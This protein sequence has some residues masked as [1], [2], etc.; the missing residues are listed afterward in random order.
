MKAKDL[1]TCIA[2]GKIK[3]PIHVLHD[4]HPRIWCVTIFVPMVVIT[5]VGVPMTFLY[6]FFVDIPRIWSNFWSDIRGFWYRN[7]RYCKQV[8]GGAWKS[9]LNG[10][11]GVR[12]CA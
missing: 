11:K 9:W 8:V 3:N 12:K 6:E 2:Y 5:I 1:K 7:K 10:W 4:S